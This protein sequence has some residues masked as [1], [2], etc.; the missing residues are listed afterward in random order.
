MQTC[1]VINLFFQ[2]YR[3]H[4]ATNRDPSTNHA[5]QR[6][7]ARVMH[8]Y[9]LAALHPFVTCQEGPKGENVSSI[10]AFLQQ[11]VP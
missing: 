8:Y 7:T 9:V 3:K 10:S 2:H 11:L 5:L 4:Q 1:V 6:E